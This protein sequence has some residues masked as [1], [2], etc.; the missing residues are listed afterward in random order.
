MLKVIEV[1]DR[2]GLK[3]FVKVAFKIYKNDP[4]FSPEPIRDQVEHLSEKNPFVRHARVH[5]FIATDGRVDLGRIAAIVNPMHNEFH[6]DR[7]GFFGFFEC[8]KDQE[9]ASALLDRASETLKAYNMDTIRGPMNFS[10]NE[11]CGVLVQ[12]FDIA[13]TIM[14]PYNPPYYKDLLEGAGF[15]K[16]KDLHA[17]MRTIPEEL[18]EKAL[19]VAEVA[20]RRGITVRKVKLKNLYEELVAF[21]DIY[22]NA[23]K[24]NWGFVPFTEEELRYVAKKLKPVIVPELMLIAEHEGEPVGFLGLLPDLSLVLRKMGGRLTPWSILKALYWYRKI[25]RLRLL[26]L[27]IKK[28]YR[29]RGV[30]ALL[31]REGFKGAKKYK[32]VEF[33]WILEDNLPVIRL[34]EMI[35]GTLSRVFRVYERPI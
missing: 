24:E 25:D 9:V 16:A 12:G 8:I 29:F 28:D 22:Y 35:G 31:F 33:S 14:T 26:L 18:P 1:N 13:P 5:Y 7:T 17:Y 34:V 3:R 21:N 23:W 19:R 30:D 4:L 20:E 11:Y 32:E 6:K 15:K 27:G 2:V 10:T